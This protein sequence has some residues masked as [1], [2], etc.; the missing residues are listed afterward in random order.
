MCISPNFIAKTLEIY[1]ENP[2]LSQFFFFRNVITKF[3]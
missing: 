1:S 3:A 2:D